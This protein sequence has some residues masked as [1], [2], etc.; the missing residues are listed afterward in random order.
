[1][2]RI[3]LISDIHANQPALEA[4]LRDIEQ[5]QCSAIYCLG[6]I[7]GYNANPVECLE[8]VKG[9]QIPTVRG[10]HDEEAIC[11]DNPQYMNPVAYSAL[12]WT[13]NQLNEDHRKYLRRAP[14]Q[15]I[16]PN[17]V[18]LVHATQDKP[19][20]WAYVTNCDLAT[21]SLNMLVEGRFLC[22]NGHTHVPRAFIQHDGAVHEYELGDIPLYKEFKYLINVGSVGQPRDG[23][24]RASYGILDEDTMTFYHRRIEYDV[25]ET[26]RRIINAGLPEMLATRLSAGI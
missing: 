19:N 13:R 21:H 17:G 23:D 3:A 18:V 11:D 4:V 5:L 24:I 12:M 2:S 6:D 20:S 7:V 9:L 16:Q 25:A 26:Q 8:L 1:M 22:F 15:R 10:N 14:F